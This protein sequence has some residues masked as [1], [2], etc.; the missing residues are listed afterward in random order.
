MYRE[1][2]AVAT[3]ADWALPFTQSLGDPHFKTGTTKDNQ[4]LLR[5]LIAF[6]VIFEGIFF[7]V[8]FTQ[9][10]SLGRRN[11]LTGVSQQFQYILR[12]ESMHMNFGIDVINQIKI[13]NPDLWSQSFQDEKINLIKQGVELET[14]YARDTMPRPIL[15]MNAE[16]F[17][18]YLK[19]IANRRFVQIGLPEQYPGAKNTF[20]WMSEIMD[21]KKEKNFFET[22]V[23]EYQTGGQLKFD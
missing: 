16:L 21:L 4:R 11:K 1:I 20:E 5:D 6:Y 17:E 7:Y 9:I 13:E 14:Q 8:G 22:R 2:P 10:L 18:E 23:T 12:D 19:F 15:G 3:K